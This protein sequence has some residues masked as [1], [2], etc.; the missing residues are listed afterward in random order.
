MKALYVKTPG[1]E[2]EL[3]VREIDTPSPGEG[4]VLIKVASAGLCNHDVAIMRGLLRRGVNPDVILGHEIAG[5]VEEAG[6]GTSALGAGARVVANLT[7][8]CGECE[9]CVTGHEYRCVTGRGV[10]HAVN[11]GFAEYVTLPERCLVRLP[12]SVDLDTAS[13]L[14]CPIAVTLQALKDVAKTRPG[15]TV[16]VT[17]A[18][19]GLGVHA[20]Q[21]ATALGARVLAATS[22]PEKLDGLEAYAPGGVIL[23][24]E[25]DFSEIALALSEDAGADVVIDTVGSA[26]FGSS[27]RSL[28]QFG[29]LVVLGEVE[30]QR[31]NFNLA[32]VIFRDAAVV[33]SS[34]AGKAQVEEVVRMVADGE[35][36]PVISDRVPLAS[37]RDA[38]DLVGSRQAL[39]RVVLVP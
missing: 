35:V 23:G 2:P 18:G 27:L 31:V 15:E 17:G 16:L 13:V 1:E 26:T 28:T 39:G 6:P 33:G 32:E 11:G 21:V 9:R 30:G 37:A 25:L 29:R 19:G 10:G 20:L 4:E 7:V 22:S 5:A 3:E 24:G 38:F 12:E 8:F 34:G 14:A 36:K